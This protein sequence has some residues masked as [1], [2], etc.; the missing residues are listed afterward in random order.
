MMINNETVWDAGVQQH[1]FREM[2]EVFSRPG[3][4]RDISRWTGSAATL[5]GVLATLIDQETTLADPHD[6]IEERSWPL[7][8]ARR[9]LSEAARFIVA[10]GD[11]VPDFQ[12]P[13][14]SLESP[15]YGATVVVK[16]QSLKGGDTSMRLTGPGIEK[17]AV[18]NCSGLNSQWLQRREE[19]VS[20]FPLGVDML[21]IDTACITALPRTTRIIHMKRDN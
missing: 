13:T 5:L 21:F 4:V 18:L 15:E 19:W 1:I 6:L 3:T 17:S 11:R 14:G 8:Q 9:E 12:P 10:R 7:L 20:G 16:V 2:L